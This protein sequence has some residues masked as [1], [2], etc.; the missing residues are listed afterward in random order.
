[1]KKIH[2]RRRKP[3]QKAHRVSPNQ[4]GRAAIQ[5][6]EHP[7]RIKDRYTYRTFDFSR[8]PARNGGEYV[9]RK[10]EDRPQWS[11]LSLAVRRAQSKGR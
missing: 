11:K 4:N 10:A 3:H 9:R 5:T 2:L 1:M 6:H 8:S 7:L